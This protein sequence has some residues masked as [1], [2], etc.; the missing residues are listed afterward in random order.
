MASDDLPVKSLI[1][2]APR[3]ERDDSLDVTAD[4]GEAPSVISFDIFTCCER[5][6][7][8]PMTLDDYLEM[9]D[10]VP[11]PDDPIDKEGYFVEMPDFGP[12]FLAGY[13]GYTFWADKESFEKKFEKVPAKLN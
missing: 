2:D 6:Y 9:R 13:S 7:A 4:R 11:H 10:W 5:V 8:T 12:G 1:L 3:Q